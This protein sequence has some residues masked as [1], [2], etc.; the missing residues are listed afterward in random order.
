[1]AG[2][3]GLPI[4]TGPKEFAA[5]LNSEIPRRAR[6]VKESGAKVDSLRPRQRVA[7]LLRA[8]RHLWLLRELERSRYRDDSKDRHGR[9]ALRRAR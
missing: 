1:M 4:K 9:Q 2:T 3:G 8:R 6:I 7:Q 5:L